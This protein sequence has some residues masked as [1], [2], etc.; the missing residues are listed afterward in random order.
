[1]VLSN[2]S[3]IITEYYHAY[4]ASNDVLVVFKYVA[5]LVSQPKLRSRFESGHRR[6]VTA[7]NQPASGLSEGYAPNGNTGCKTRNVGIKLRPLT[8]FFSAG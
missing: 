2:H 5:E 8:M 6:F 4:R 1:M 7:G 3:R